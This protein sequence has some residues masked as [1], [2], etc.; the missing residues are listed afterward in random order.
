MA[1]KAKTETVGAEA[2]KPNQSQDTAGSDL[3]AVNVQ[4]AEKTG[5]L[6]SFDERLQ[7][8]ENSR[9]TS[10]TSAQQQSAAILGVNTITGAEPPASGGNEGVGLNFSDTQ[11][12]YEGIRDSLAKIVLPPYFKVND[13]ATGIK[14]ESKPTLKVLSK[15]ARYTETGLKLL[16]TFKKTDDGTYVISDDEICALYTIL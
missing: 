13:S 5:L 11:K 12:E 16:S 2:E 3:I 15:T 4:L 9:P 7:R 10:T 14:A 8:I 6:K 1:D